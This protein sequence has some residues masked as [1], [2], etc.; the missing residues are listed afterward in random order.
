MTDID[1]NIYDTLIQDIG[2]LLSKGRTES[3]KKVNSI[4]VQ[5]Y[6]NIGK[7]IVEHEQRGHEKA[8]YGSRLLRGL[9]HDLKLQYGKGFSRSNLQYMRLLYIKYPKYQ[10]VSGKLTWS[11]YTELLSISEDLSRS[12]YEKQCILENWSVR[13]LKRQRQSGLF[14]RIALSKDKSGVLK[15]AQQQIKMKYWLTMQQVPSPINCL[16]QNISYIS[17]IKRCL[18]MNYGYY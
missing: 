1:K 12:F 5:T 17:P 14:E 10:T 2:I 11:H 3:Y 6:W 8:E 9:S 7:I 15:L 16:F 18:K 13:E 4:L